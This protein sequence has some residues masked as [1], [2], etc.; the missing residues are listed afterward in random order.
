M[1]HLDEIGDLSPELQPKL[2]KALEE[3]RFRRLGDV[4]ERQVDVRLVAATHQDLQSLVRAKQF[5]SDLYFRISTLPL[6]IPPLRERAEDIL[7]LSRQLLTQLAAGRCLGEFKLAPEAER[8]LVSY[9]WPGNIR[10]LRNVLERAVLLSECSTLGVRDLHFDAAAHDAA[11]T[12]ESDLTLEE[13]ERRHIGRVL[14][15]ERGHVER[16]ARRLNVPRSSLYQKIKR[17]GLNGVRSLESS[18]EF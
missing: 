1:C 7:P 17:Y 12:D 14:Q 10:E 13:L 11:P 18:S 6:R 2:L 15:E 8:A 4:R 16:A 9:G 3:R 5:R